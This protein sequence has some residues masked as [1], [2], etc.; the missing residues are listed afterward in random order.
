MDTTI[1][2]GKFA[3]S[4]SFEEVKPFSPNELLV[5][6]KKCIHGKIGLQKSLEFL[7]PGELECIEIEH[8]LIGA[9][10]AN[11]SLLLKINKT[12]L[13][14]ILKEKVFPHIRPEDLIRVDMKIKTTYK[15]ID[16]SNAK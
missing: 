15:V 5:L 11:K 13:I 14:N 1:S 8:E 4:L 10:F 9:I 6:G 7:Y 2:K 12:I 3:I 16:I